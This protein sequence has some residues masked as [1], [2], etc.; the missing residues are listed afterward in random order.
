VTVPRRSELSL[1]I[2]SAAVLI[3]GVLAL[4]WIGGVAFDIMVTVLAVLMAIEWD[5]L[6]NAGSSAPEDG[7]VLRAGF[8]LAATAA[9]ITAWTGFSYQHLGGEPD[10]AVIAAILLA[11]IVI[12]QAEQIVRRRQ[13]PWLR[14]IGVLYICVPSVAFMVLR[15]EPD[16]AF[17]ILW[18][19][20]AVWATDIGAYAVGRKFGGPKLAPRVSPNKTWSGAIGGAIAAVI[21][22]APLSLV[23][24][25]FDLMLAIPAAFAV[26]IVSQCGDLAESAVKRHLQVKDSG[27]IIPGHGGLFDRLDGLLAA[28]PLALA[29][30]I[31]LV[32]PSTA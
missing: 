30:N 32:T 17:W 26:S 16:G 18:L 13:R 10:I 19:F 4:D 22:S 1:R 28:A 11:G 27:T 6:M 25:E 9:V 23:M 20:I 2:I 15:H 21:L 14:A 31:Y 12:C 3:P 24:D 7:K 29:I 8:G 5:N